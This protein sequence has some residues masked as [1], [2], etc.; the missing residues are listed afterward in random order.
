MIAKAIDVHMALVAVYKCKVHTWDANV[1]ATEPG[2]V[3]T[4]QALKQIASELRE[5]YH[6]VD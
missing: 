1:M 2:A 3:A 4:H 5:R 6:L